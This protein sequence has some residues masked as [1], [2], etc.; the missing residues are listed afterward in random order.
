MP[1]LAAQSIA[2]TRILPPPARY[3]Y[4]G[5]ETACVF[6]ETFLSWLTPPGAANAFRTVGNLFFDLMLNADDWPM[7]SES[8]VRRE[9][10]AAAQDLRFVQG[11]LATALETNDMKQM[12]PED[13]Y[14]LRL[15]GRLA[16]QVGRIA[17]TIETALGE[18]LR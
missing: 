7:P 6:R 8:P 17:A 11:W 4:T 1:E 16:P 5:W 18:E 12:H 3:P 2:S 14:F 10:R 15:A 9:L 13:A